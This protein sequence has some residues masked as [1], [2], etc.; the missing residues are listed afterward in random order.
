[1][2]DRK[3][4]APWWVARGSSIQRLV[5][6]VPGSETPE[7]LAKVNRERALYRL[8]LG[9]PDQTDL[10]QLISSGDRWDQATVERACLDLSAWGRL[11]GEAD[12]DPNV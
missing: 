10:L 11:I 12:Q 9:M 4:L 2:T 3:G 5:F 8:V 1:M 6:S 7:R